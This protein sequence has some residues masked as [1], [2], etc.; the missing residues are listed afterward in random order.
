PDARI[1]VYWAGAPPYYAQRP[2]IDLLGKN[3]ARI[4][5]EPARNAYPGHNKRD[6]AYSIGW[7]RPDVVADFWGSPVRLARWGYVPVSVVRG[8][9]RFAFWV[10]DGSPAVRWNR[11]RVG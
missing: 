1:A 7:L 10:L 2:S 3:D 4:A 9:T 11:L 6:Y 5:R 8:D